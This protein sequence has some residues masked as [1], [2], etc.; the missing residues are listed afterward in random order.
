M[1]FIPIVGRQVLPPSFPA[2]SLL[3]W[4]TPSILKEKSNCSART[5]PMASRN[6]G[7][8]EYGGMYSCSR[9]RIQFHSRYARCKR[10]GPMVSYKTVL[11]SVPQNHTPQFPFASY[12]NPHHPIEK[13]CRLMLIIMKTQHRRQIPNKLP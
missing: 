10:Q 1:N 3:F 9:L 2:H 12:Q 8:K 4:N 5:C 6:Q 13:C 7:P 11:P